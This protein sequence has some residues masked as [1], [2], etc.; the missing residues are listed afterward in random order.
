MMLNSTKASNW[1]SI[2]Y[3]TNRFQDIWN[4]LNVLNSFSSSNGSHTKLAHSMRIAHVNGKQTKCKNHV[5]V[6]VSNLINW[7]HTKIIRCEFQINRINEKK[8]WSKKTDYTLCTK[9]NWAFNFRILC[10]K[11]S[12]AFV[13]CHQSINFVYIFISENIID[14]TFVVNW[15][16][17]SWAH[18]VHTLCATHLKSTLCGLK[19]ISSNCVLI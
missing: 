8:K 13:E 14:N 1:Y 19:S 4:G 17:L 15:S 9:W 3:F 18:D 10:N 2:F 11:Q 6:L 12:I 7:K 16:A 5:I